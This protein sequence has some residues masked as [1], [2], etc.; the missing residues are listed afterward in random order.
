MGREGAGHLA[1]VFSSSQGWSWALEPPSPPVCAGALP[2]PCLA[3]SPC[4][5]FGLSHLAPAILPASADQPPAVLPLSAYPWVVQ[6]IDLLIATWQPDRASVK[7]KPHHFLCLR[8]RGGPGSRQ[9]PWLAHKTPQAVARQPPMSC[10][11]LLPHPS[12]TSH[13]HPDSLPSPLLPLRTLLSPC[14]EDLLPASPLPLLKTQLLS[15]QLRGGLLQEVFRIT[16]WLW[17][18]TFLHVPTKPTCIT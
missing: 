5:S 8:R 11:M 1:E 16:M 18:Y 17:L 7:E 10:Q 13:S 2:A 6:R 15:S 14:L 12:S 3:S 9:L 4:V